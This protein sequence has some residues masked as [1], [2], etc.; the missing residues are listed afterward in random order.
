MEKNLIEYNFEGNLRI[1]QEQNRI[2]IKRNIQS[3]SIKNN[4]LFNPNQLLLILD[5]ES[6][7]HDFKDQITITPT[8]LENSFRIK[9][10]DENIVY[11]GCEL[12]SNQ[13]IIIILIY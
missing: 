8:G 10:Q 12:Y 9:T 11:F 4:I 7:N 1:K 6:Q 5:I 2:L 13:V 3:Q